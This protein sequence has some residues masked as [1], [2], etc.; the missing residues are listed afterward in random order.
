MNEKLLLKL[1]EKLP[2]YTH[3]AI[4]TD[5]S[6]YLVVNPEVYLYKYH[7]TRLNAVFKRFEARCKPSLYITGNRLYFTLNGAKYWTSLSCF[8]SEWEYIADLLEEIEPLVCDVAY[9]VGHLD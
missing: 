8:S 9:E 3:T 2:L 1:T 7:D 6:K 5:M 4:D